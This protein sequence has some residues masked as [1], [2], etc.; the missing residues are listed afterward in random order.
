MFKAFEKG[1]LY[2]FGLFCDRFRPGCL[3]AAVSSLPGDDRL[4]N[5]GVSLRLHTQV[6]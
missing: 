3:D 2:V 6:C 4:V 1:M 5:P